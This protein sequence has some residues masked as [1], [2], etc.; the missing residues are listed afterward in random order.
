LQ[1]LFVDMRVPQALRAA[2]PIIATPA[3]IVWVAGLRAAEGFPATSESQT[4]IK[5][6]IARDA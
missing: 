3:V 6:R 4:I 1:D 2:W 5:I